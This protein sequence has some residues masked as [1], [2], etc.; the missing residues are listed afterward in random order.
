MPP[1]RRQYVSGPELQA[2]T[3]WINNPHDPNHRT[4]AFRTNSIEANRSTNSIADLLGFVESVQDHTPN[5][6][7]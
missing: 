2:L 3:G 5:I 7:T 6:S 4:A 1:D